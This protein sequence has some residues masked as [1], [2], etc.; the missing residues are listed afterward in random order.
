MPSILR[1][2]E[3]IKYKTELLKLLVLPPLAIGGGSLGV[4]LGALTPIRI[5]LA[6]AG[7]V[8]TAVIVL[9]VV[10]H[11]RTTERLIEQ[12]EEGGS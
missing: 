6:A 10:Q 5:A 2:I 4:A 1:Q 3:R 11:H 8:F 12:V 9:G 7:M